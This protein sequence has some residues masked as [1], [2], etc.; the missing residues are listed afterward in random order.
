MKTMNDIVRRIS[1]ELKQAAGAATPPS[2][3]A[4]A[5]YRNQYPEPLADTIKREYQKLC[6]ANNEVFC[7]DSQTIEL[8]DK[9]AE[10]LQSD[11][12][13]WLVIYGP[14]GLG[15]TNILH[16]SIAA[17]K[18]R[19]AN[20]IPDLFTSNQIRE[21]AAKGEAPFAWICED[22]AFVAIDDIGS[23]VP[24]GQ[25]NEDKVNSYGTSRSPLKTVLLERYARNLRTIITTNDNISKLAQKYG[26]RFADRITQKSLV[27]TIVLAGDSFR[28]VPGAVRLK[29]RS[30]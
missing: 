29:T 26:D 13:K 28:Q 4:I 9:V 16:A 15:K 19:H 30:R 8:I 10:F 3:P 24:E 22:L 25:A 17:L 7:P 20:R 18:A 5:F 27:A 23:E 6:E 2:S 21:Y 14:K 1:P 11:R 12:Y